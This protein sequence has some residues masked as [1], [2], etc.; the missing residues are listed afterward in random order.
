MI[1][2]GIDLAWQS[3]K[4]GT[5]VAFGT[6]D[7]GCLS[8]N[9][10]ESGL[11]SLAA[12]SAQLAR[13]PDLHG[14]A[15]DGPLIINN[16]SGQRQCETLV[17]RE[18]GARKASCHTS[19][20]ERYPDSASVSL[21]RA[22]NEQGFVHLGTTSKWQIECYPHPALIEIFGLA[23]RLP[24]KKGRIQAKR[25]G[26]EELGRLLRKLSD[27]PFL[28]LQIPDHLNQKLESSHIQE[29]SGVKL[30]HNEDLLDAVVCL[31]I[32]GLYAIGCRDKVFGDS[33]NGYIYVPQCRCL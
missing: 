17:G 10:A 21:S 33:D 1:L 9:H 30:K 13:Y 18:Y 22:L 14:V 16:V 5:G 23:E 27:S 19:N 11:N 12:I 32:A 26:Q 15:I 2:A 28:A 24:Y 25:D 3:E 20:L 4:N 31:Y 29:L 6:L 8:V 7:R